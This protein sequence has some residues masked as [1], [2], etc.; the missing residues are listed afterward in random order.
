[1][2]IFTLTLTIILGECGEEKEE[3]EKY[4]HRWLREH[5][6]VTLY[7]KREEYEWLKEL[8]DRKG[9]SISELV[10]EVIKNAKEFYYQGED[11]GIDNTLDLFIDYPFHFYDMLMGRAEERG[12]R[13]FEP[14]LFT[15]PC[16]ICGKP[17]VYTHRDEGWASKVKPTLRKILGYP[18][19]AECLK[20]L[21]RG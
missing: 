4:I 7:L 16:A 20:K 9:T 11:A 19:H 1:M 18:V 6:R 14:C 15:I 2:L 12:L 3:G 10:R 13:G 21:K 5:P 17:I 8:A